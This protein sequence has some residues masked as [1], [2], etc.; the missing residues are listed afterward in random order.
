MGLIKDFLLSLKNKKSEIPLDEEN[1]Q[2]KEKI[3]ELENIIKE[4]DIE[5]AEEIN[6][7]DREFLTWYNQQNTK[8]TKETANTPGQQSE[9]RQEEL[10]LEELINEQ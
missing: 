1:K 6:L 4:K 3:I 7:I 5:H 2:L 9:E 8:I 10:N